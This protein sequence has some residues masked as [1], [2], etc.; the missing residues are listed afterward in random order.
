MVFAMMVQARSLEEISKP[1]VNPLLTTAI[2]LASISVS[3]LS[4]KLATIDPEIL[5]L[6]LSHRMSRERSN[7]C[8]EKT[9]EVAEILRLVDAST[10]SLCLSEVS[11]G[12]VP[13]DEIRC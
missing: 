13:Q 1:L 2:G 12:R 7:V 4:R 10:I 3:Q 8:A 11:V 6:L 9:G 5:H